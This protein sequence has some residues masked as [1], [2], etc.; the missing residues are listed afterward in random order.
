VDA[1]ANI[2]KP[3]AWSGLSPAVRMSADC[4]ATQSVAKATRTQ[5]KQGKED[6]RSK[7]RLRAS[8]RCTV[9]TVS[10]RDAHLR[11]VRA[12][13]HDPTNVRLRILTL[14]GLAALL[15]CGGS[16]AARPK[17]PGDEVGTTTPSSRS[18]QAAA[19]DA[20][21]RSPHG[22]QPGLSAAVPAGSALSAGPSYLEHTDRLGH[23]YEQLAGLEEARAQ[24]D[25]VIL[26]YGDSHTASD[27]GAGVLRH[28]LQARFGDGG[29][30]F[31]SLGRPWK[32]YYQEG[33]HGGMTREFEPAKVTFSS[34][35]IF[36]GDGAFGLLGV[37][38]EASRAGARAW[39]E[40]KVSASHVEVAYL[41]QPQGG[42]FDVLVD[43]VGAGRVGTRA[44]QERSG[45]FGFDVADGTHTI[46]ARPVGDGVVRLFG[47]TLDRPEPGV[48]VD[49]LGI[50]GA[51]IFTPLR[52]SEEHFGEQV[53][54]AAPGLVVLAYGTNEAVEQGLLDADYERRLAEL[55]ERVARA[56]PGAS[57]LLLGPPDLARRPKGQTEWKTWPRVVEIVAMQR[58][59]A[60]AAGCAFF[61]QLAAMGG[62][63]SMAA[64]AVGPEP[65]ARGDRVHLTRAGYTQL[66]T[67]LATDLMHGYDEWRAE[68]GLPPSA[69]KAVASR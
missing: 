31:V 32:G 16:T 18:T 12:L 63:G 25:V 11:P 15:G 45:F 28:A 22:T 65:R 58:R 47:L 26:Q 44:P 54:H 33:V 8:K 67:A 34:K 57:C 66:A 49:T 42:S 10:Q 1:S 23:V 3:N 29:R 60:E 6:K 30:G 64:W 40:V 20:V 37:A 9:Q 62:P 52:W 50:N 21:D 41:E 59:V 5:G 69:Q 43:G 7:K 53:R 55:L 27:I 48:V 14:A 36:A 35:G 38:V 2:R 68:R 17:G 46:E 61:D 13:C 39:T 51:Q 4:P 19:A 56:A 24:R